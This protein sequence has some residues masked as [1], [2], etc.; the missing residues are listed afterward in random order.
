MFQQTLLNTQK[1]AKQYG[2]E[3][4]YLRSKSISGDNSSDLEW[5][6]ELI[7]KLNMN[8]IIPKFFAHVRPTTPL[9]DPKKS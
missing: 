1:I 3:V 5:F 7:K 9:R 4:P 6:K 2:A 8:E